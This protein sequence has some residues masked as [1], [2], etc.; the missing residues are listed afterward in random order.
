MLLLNYSL[1][2]TLPKPPSSRE[3][4]RLQAVEGV[5]FYADFF[6]LALFGGRVKPAGTEMGLF[7]LKKVMRWL[8][9]TGGKFRAKTKGAAA[10]PED[11]KRA[12]ERRLADVPRGEV[13]IRAASG[14]PLFPPPACACIGRDE[15]G[16]LDIWPLY[17]GVEL[18]LQAYSAKSVAFHHDVPG[19]AMLEINHCY[20][21]RVGYTSGAEPALY[22]GE[23]D[24]SLHGLHT[25][26]ESVM[27]FPFD[28][29][30]GF[31]FRVDVA[32]LDGECPAFMREAGVSGAQILARFCGENGFSVLS[33]A[34]QVGALLDPLYTL[35]ERLLIP[36]A[37]LKFQELML[38]LSVMDAPPVTQSAY[39]AEQIALI[40]RIH[41]Q[42]MSDMS[43]RCTI[44][45]L[46]QQYHI[47]TS[48]L[49]S[50]FKTV[51]G[52]PL[53]AHM[54]EHRMEYAARLLRTTTDSLAEIAEKVGYES[55]SKLTAAFKSAY[56]VLPSEY[57]KEKK[58][59]SRP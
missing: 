26:V 21:G 30:L 3:G 57:R 59:N 38:L 45:M 43:Q 27:Q 2:K 35:P 49:K 46:S 12:L 6:I 54:K 56:G 52:Q 22:L 29:Y 47:N 7:R 8:V 13:L 58:E 16:R 51:Y 32:R 9:M 1:G 50:L 44:E 17:P 24:L 42:M 36:Y 37:K 18:T 14:A 31:S 10:M 20:V 40:R 33:S 55:Q 25:G 39:Q 15:K 19:A 48:T 53:A 28:G 5:S 41:D 11:W 34:E 23:G 4:G